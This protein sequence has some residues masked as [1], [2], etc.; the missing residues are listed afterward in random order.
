MKWII[1]LDVDKCSACGA[2]AIACMDQNDIEAGVQRPFRQVFAL[3]RAEAERLKCTYISSA[4]MHC[5]TAPCVNG[6]PSGCLYKD[7]ETGFTLFDNSVCIGCHACSMACPFGAPSFNREGKLEKCDGCYLRLADGRL[8]A[9]VQAC[10]T[11]ALKVYGKAEYE[12][13]QNGRLLR[14]LLACDR[15]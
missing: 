9:C 13:E 15:S 2:C 6:C 5:D 8:P 4:C 10:P 11:G 3:E 14:V 12:A 7:P 1:D